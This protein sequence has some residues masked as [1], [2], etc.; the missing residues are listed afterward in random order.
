MAFLSDI[1]GRVGRVARGQANAG[2]DALEHA[3]CEP[4]GQ[5][6][7]ADMKT[8]L[9]RVV[10]ASAVAL[11]NYNRL[12]A[13]N[14]KYVR[15]SQEWKDRAGVALDA[16]NEDLARKALAK[17]AECD[18]QVAS[19]ATA[20]QSAQQTSDKLKQ[21]VMELKRKI[22]EGERTANTLVARKNAATA[23]RKVAEAMSGV[24][25]ADN[26]FSQ[27]NR[28]E[29]SVAKEEPPPK[30]STNSPPRARTI[31]WNSSSP[32][33]AA[34]ASIRNWKR[35]EKSGRSRNIFPRSFQRRPARRRSQGRRYR[36]P[37][38]FPMITLTVEAL[39]V[40]LLVL[41]LMQFFKKKPATPS[42]PEPDLANLK[43]TDARAGDAIS[44]SG[45]GDDYS[46]LD[47][48]ADRCTWVQAGSHHW[49]E[50]SGPY[51]DRRVSMR[52]S[53][54]AD[55]DVDV[56]IHTDPRK[57]TLADFGLSEPDTHRRL[58][59]E[60]QNT[61]DWFEFDNKNWLYRLS[62]QKPRPK[63]GNQGQP[64]GF[65]YWEFQ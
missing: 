23:Q 1:F 40:V 8:E 14:Q 2:V 9:N 5:Q 36:L 12:D 29:E 50:L 57:L 11:S 64:T 43:P 41:V 44:I 20:V 52:V 25:N 46:D 65:Y 54:N 32:P 21:Q 33:L 4:T 10:Q 34:T 16:G 17:K 56:A 7:V 49:S 53:T 63:S 45:A 28:F 60:R 48:T 22:D 6:T 47:F 35:S 13:E 18:Q 15:Q 62:R 19:M 39:L 55:G 31:I 37:T 38:C 3:K 30:R 59:D 26:A 58:L 24:G 27:L 42:E 51:K 61:E